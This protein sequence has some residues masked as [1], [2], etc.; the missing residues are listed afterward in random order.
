MSHGEFKGYGSTFGGPLDSYGDVIAAGAFSESLATHKT[1]KTMPA[2]LWHH[3]ASEP[4]GRW[5]ELRE[6]AT[7]LAV[8]GKLTLG[9][10]RGS[11]AYALM[12]DEALGLSIG[13]RIP[14]GGAAYSREKR[15]LK[16]VD[17][18]EIS[19]V[20]L[21]SNHA[22]RIT[23]VKSAQIKPGNIRDFQAMLRER[24]GFSK[25]EALRISSAGWRAFLNEEDEIQKHDLAALLAK[26]TQSFSTNQGSNHGSK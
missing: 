15:T 24:L 1:R 26:A 6:D 21:P 18:V 10:T 2:M 17:L 13:F 5:L 8:T 19:L 23:H 7:G 14:S 25:D 9:T 4:I 3:D 16:K 11:E 22:A 12:K 20:A